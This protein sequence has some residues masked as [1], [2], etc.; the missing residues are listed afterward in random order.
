M[1]DTRF[2]VGGKFA[3]RKIVGSYKAGSLIKTKVHIAI[4]HWG[5]CSL[6]WHTSGSRCWLLGPSPDGRHLQP[7]PRSWHPTC[8]MCL[9]SPAAS[10]TSVAG[11]GLS[12]VSCAGY[13]ELRLCPLSGTTDAAEQKALSEHCFAKHPLAVKLPTGK[14]NTKMWM[15]RTGEIRPPACWTAG[16]P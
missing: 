8:H 11:Q 13:F 15:Y 2:E 3:Q 6:T 4:N 14:F 9:A 16:S 10:C 12:E 1:G 7:A 5:E